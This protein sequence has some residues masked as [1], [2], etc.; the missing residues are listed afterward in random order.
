MDDMDAALFLKEREEKLGGK[1]TYRAYALFYGSSG[2]EKREYGVFLYSNGNTFCFED[3]ER[4]PQILGIP[5]KRKNKEPYVKLEHSFKKS[6]VVDVEK[7]Y[8]SSALDV[9]AGLASKA[10]RASG[11]GKVLKKTVTAVTLSDGTVYFFELMDK[12]RLDDILLSKEG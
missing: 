9:I 4:E 8:Q 7:V 6:D 12:N 2:G 10:K 5:I 11:I 1:I 3:F